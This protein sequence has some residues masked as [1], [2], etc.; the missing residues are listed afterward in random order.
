MASVVCRAVLALQ[1]GAPA[2]SIG[3][4]LLRHGS[5]DFSVHQAAGMVAVQGAI[6]V[7]EALVRLR[8]HA[9]AINVTATTLAGYVIYREVLFDP[10]A[11]DW[12]ETG[13]T[14][15]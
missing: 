9:F 15:R 4:E 14:M 7:G 2:D 10:L 5:F 3:D 8:A 13:A 1:A 6:S 11:R 12:K